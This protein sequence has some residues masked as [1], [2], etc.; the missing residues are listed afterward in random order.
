MTLLTN[1]WLTLLIGNLNPH[2]NHTSGYPT[3]S[4]LKN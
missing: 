4:S 1:A 2:K 3:N